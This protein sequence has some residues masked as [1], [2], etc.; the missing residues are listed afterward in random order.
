MGSDDPTPM[1]GSRRRSSRG[2][3]PSEG[4]R[5]QKDG[6]IS[7]KSGT[8]IT[9]VA[10]VLGAGGG[11]TLMSV[12]Q[13]PSPEVLERLDAIEQ[14]LSASE[15]AQAR[16]ARLTGIIYKTIIRANPDAAIPLE[17]LDLDDHP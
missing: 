16:G 5:V 11:T 3:P 4:I 12:L 1:A 8:I 17:D 14:R 15:A 13:Q 10:G 6:T 2:G 7:I 9:I